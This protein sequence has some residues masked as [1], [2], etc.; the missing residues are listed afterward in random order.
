[1]RIPSDRDRNHN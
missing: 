1:M